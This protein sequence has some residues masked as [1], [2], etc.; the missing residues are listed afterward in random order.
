MAVGT[1]SRTVRSADEVGLVVRAA[2][3]LM[4]FSQAPI[5]VR[6]PEAHAVTLFACVVPWLGVGEDHKLASTSPSTAAVLETSGVA[7]T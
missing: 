5:E 7:E 4:P 1:G 3:T 6:Q 2:Q